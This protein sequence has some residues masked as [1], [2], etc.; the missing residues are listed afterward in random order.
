MLVKPGIMIAGFDQQPYSRSVCGGG[1]SK[2]L[3]AVGRP[4]SKFTA[5]RHDPQYSEYSKT[6]YAA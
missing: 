3:Q 4:C 6:K 1:S 5:W 2:G